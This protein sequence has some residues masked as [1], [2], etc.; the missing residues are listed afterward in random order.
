MSDLS[1]Q[2]R[3]TFKYSAEQL[4]DVWISPDSVVAPVTAIEV[5]P[6]TD[7]LFKLTAAGERS[8]H[9]LGKFLEFERPSKLVYTWEWNNDG[10]VSQVAVEFNPLDDGTEVIINHTGF[11]KASSRETH[12]N[13]WDSY[14][15][16]ITKLL[17]NA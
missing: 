7:G 11:D 1:I 14:V 17:E 10:E 13:G 9:M 3:Y 2:K 12:D 15:A 4:F 5:E 8:S 6:H 16:G